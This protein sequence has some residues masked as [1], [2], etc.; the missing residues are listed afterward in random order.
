[1]RLNLRTFHKGL[2]LIGL[3]LIINVLLVA[4][5]FLLVIQADNERLE[6][7]RQKKIYECSARLGYLLYDSVYTLNNV[8]LSKDI[9]QYGRIKDELFKFVKTRT[10]LM[11][12][13]DRDPV[14]STRFRKMLTTDNPLYGYFG[15]LQDL[16]HHR[17]NLRTFSQTV[18]HAKEDALVA[19]GRMSETFGVLIAESE[20]YLINSPKKQAVI[21]KMQLASLLGGVLLNIAAAFFLVKFFMTDI[22]LRLNVMK[23]NS[24]RLANGE[25]LQP[26]LTG[27]DEIAE[28]DRV[29]HRVADE[30]SL[31]AQRERASFDKAND[32]ICVLD[33]NGR[34]TRINAACER[35]WGHLPER[36]IGESLLELVADEDKDLTGKSM[37]A[38]QTS[39]PATTFECKMI[40]NN[41]QPL[42]TLWSTYWSATDGALFCVV[43]DITERK[44]SERLKEEFLSM[45]RQNLQ[46]PLKAI[47]EVF[48]QFTAKAFGELPDLAASKIAMAGNNI[49]RLLKLVDDLFTVEHLQSTTLELNCQ[50]ISVSDL[51][52]KA[53]QEIE[54][55]AEKK[56][57]KL[58]VE[59]SAGT[60][61]LDQ[62]RMLQVLVNLLS[63]AIKFSPEGETVTI[64]AKHSPQSLRIAVADNGRGVPASHRE[65]IF[66]RFRQV[67]AADGRRKSGTGLG[68]PICKQIVEQHGG[69]IGV[70]SE[71]GLGSSFWLEIPA[72]AG[73]TTTV[74]A[75][76]ESRGLQRSGSA[77]SN[78][79]SQPTA[80][81]QASSKFF[82]LSSNLSL[83]Q[84]GAVLAG[85]PVVLGLIF[86]AILGLGLLEAD[87]ETAKVRHTRAIAVNASKLM[88]L[89]YKVGSIVAQ[90][91]TVK[92]WIQFKATADEIPRTYL[93]LCKLAEGNQHLEATL[94]D[95][96]ISLTEPQAF[97]L[98]AV[99]LVDELGH[100]KS[101]LI[102]AYKGREA[103]EPHLA[104]A[105]RL[106][107]QLVQETN[108]MEIDDPVGVA[109][110]HK[111]QA[112]LLLVALGFGMATSILLA[113]F[114]SR[115][116]T[117]RLS[118]L[119]DN[120]RRLAANLP[121]S[122]PLSGNDEIAH[123]DR[124]F[125]SMALVLR[126]SRQKERA[127]FDNSQDV[128][129]ALDRIG[130]VL[131]VNS[132]CERL[133]GHPVEQLQNSSILSIT[134]LDDRQST[135]DAIGAELTDGQSL[136]FE[137]RVVC[138]D[139]SHQDVLWSLSW[140]APEAL[141][142]GTAHDISKRKELERLKQEFLAMVSH[143][144]RTPLTAIVGVSKL[145]TAGALGELPANVKDKLNSVTVNA[146]RLLSLVNDLLDIEKL[147]C[148]QMQL[149]LEAVPVDAL[150]EQACKSVE[151]QARDASIVLAVKSEATSLFADR[152]R[153]LQVLVNL[154][155]NAIEYSAAGDEIL[156]SAECIDDLVQFKITDHGPGIP[157]ETKR[158]LFER[159]KPLAKT[160]RVENAGSGLGL[161]ICKQIVERH[162]GTI[163][164]ESA[165]GKGS[166]FW[167]RIP[168]AAKQP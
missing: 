93:E 13:V 89:I 152:E 35:L 113:V 16:A 47:H 69:E 168:A 44:Q 45:V 157:E 31:A 20:S 14:T 145:G 160:H 83:T 111:Q 64:S 166:T 29:F 110:Q 167:F 116:I 139:G 38:T 96:R 75:R 74:P 135:A 125:H 40:R 59:S 114:F 109:R 39:S 120:T 63:N 129:C 4:V 68:L 72:A 142:F 97:L 112:L 151:A 161:P 62:D 34:F 102:Q 37:Q 61:D 2:I 36:L 46:I 81:T 128:I 54:S 107:D 57:I 159:Y 164:V 156:I 149:T 98:R 134:A 131:Q 18:E 7:Y 42:S 71:D 82:A 155:N 76:L 84:K 32:V 127:V 94:A 43:H 19:S 122:E 77:E 78:A 130:T 136:T 92:R 79:S 141:H 65:T 30:L 124:V 27:F 17:L 133:W 15:I 150:I 48:R 138:Q 3:P 91:P 8:F 132:A 88:T 67:E 103:L 162:G 52:N 115:S 33:P 95:L 5:L 126:E 117:S 144:L 51:L 106:L 140:S 12:L 99:Q 147:E 22:V 105:F 85:V 165:S 87:R 108:T 66:E 154:L 73:Q 26:E 55:L 49:T 100:G 56:E 90:P 41:G 158:S 137:N 24:E 143:D 148:G 23:E 86:I 11:T 28:L 153:L 118:V 25:S 121:L 163:G 104:E 21:R 10:E 80:R 146:N 9:A 6:E 119:R 53:T 70:D 1:M 101:V 123:L 58:K 50:N 60:F